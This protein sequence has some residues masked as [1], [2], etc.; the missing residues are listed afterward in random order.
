MHGAN[1][2]SVGV[3][4]DG[5][6][7]FIAGMTGITEPPVNDLW[8]VKGEENMLEIW[9]KEDSDTFYSMDAMMFYHE[10]QIEDFLRA[11]INGTKPLV[12]GED[13]RKTVEIFT[14]I[15]RSN[16]DRAPVKFSLKPEGIK[17]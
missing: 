10:R 9:R 14:A 11:V 13:G 17:I 5:G 8:T 7:M 4:T 1:G 15:Y 2:A 6:A 12:T 3:Q 16:R